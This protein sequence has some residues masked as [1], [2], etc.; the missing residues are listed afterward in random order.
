MRTTALAI[1]GSAT[2]TSLMSRGRS[3]T[4]DLPTPSGTNARAGLAA[5]DLDHRRARLGRAR[6]RAAGAASPT[7]ARNAA[8]EAV[9]ISVV[10][11]MSLVPHRSLH[12]GVASCVTPKRTTLT[13]ALAGRSLSSGCRSICVRSRPGCA[14]RA[15]ACRAAAT[16][17]G[18]RPGAAQLERRG[19][20]DHARAGRSSPR[21]S[22][23]SPARARC[24]RMVSLVWTSA[25]RAFSASL[26]RRVRMTST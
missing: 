8:S 16:A 18:F 23:R 25:P 7:P 13:P 2:S 3:I 4:T 6:R 26:S 5:D 17:R 11:P 14:A 9:R 15:R 24:V 22:G 21:P 20:A 1:F 10:F 12:F 19:L